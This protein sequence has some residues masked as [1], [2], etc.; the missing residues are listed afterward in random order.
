MM[1]ADDSDVAAQKSNN[2]RKSN[3]P[4]LKKNTSDDLV[5]RERRVCRGGVAALFIP[6]SVFTVVCFHETMTYDDSSQDVS[7]NVNLLL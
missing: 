5:S 3:F 6:M 4:R 2:S 1:P 7:T